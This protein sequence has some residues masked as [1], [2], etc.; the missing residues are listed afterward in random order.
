MKNND[1]I[2]KDS[3]KI[4]SNPK[5]PFASINQEP[6]PAIEP[7]EV[8]A[9]EETVVEEVAEDLNVSLP[10]VNLPL[11]LK[12]IAL[13]T[14]I[15][16]LSAVGS[17]FADIFNPEDFVL[18]SYLLRL[19]AGGVFVIISYGL[20]RRANWSTWLY[21]VSVFVSLFINWPLAILPAVIVVYMYFNRKYLYPSVFD[22]LFNKAATAIASRMK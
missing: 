16:G 17:A 10:K 6:E 20:V 15:G 3:F 2:G 21:A 5:N 18:K 14:L 19:I 4:T 22:K 13:F 11:P 8:T 7:A 9:H 12:F 1:S